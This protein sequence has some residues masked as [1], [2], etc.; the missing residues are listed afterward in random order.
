MIEIDGSQGEGGGQILRTSIALSAIVGEPVKVKNIR[1]GRPK[2]G[3]SAQHVTSI[4][5][6][7][8]L[9]DAVVEGLE[10]GAHEITFRPGE[11][12][13]GDF[14]FDIGTA[15]SIS[16]AL[17]TCLLV[18]SASKGRT[19]ITMTGGTDVN[20]SPPIDY[21]KSV[22]M[23]IAERFG[24]NG[25]LELAARG[26]YPE[27]GGEVS[28][29]IA[30]CSSLQPV[31]LDSRGDVQRIGGVA[32]AQNLP[33][34]VVGRMKHAAL[35][36]LVSFKHVKIATDIRTGRSAGAGMVLFAECDTALLGESMLGRKG[37]RAEALGEGCASDLAETIESG[38]TVDFRM[39]DQILPY[40]AL[41][42]G[43]SVVLAEELTAHAETN[44]Q[45]I[46]KMLGRSFTIT[47]RD[48]LVEVA[49]G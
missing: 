14:T 45:V 35:K 1:A 43:N 3:L 15:G 29:D 9:S 39:L 31:R 22:H 46:E 26:F 44:I 11:V 18:A 2:P 40:M 25:S 34:H 20:W 4:E 30:P 19:R 28:L 21:M 32:Y 24:V 12:I 49:T 13:G 8:A 33:D 6:V 23:P 41:A 5:A 38:A 7:A 48:G 36:R 10:P 42:S 17:Q 47:E 37:L 27:G 16:L